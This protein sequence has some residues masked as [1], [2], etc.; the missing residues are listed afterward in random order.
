MAIPIRQ[1]LLAYL[2]TQLKTITIA[3]GYSTD[4]G[5]NGF[6]W[7]VTDFAPINTPGFT[8][9]DVDQTAV[10][11]PSGYSGHIANLEI[12]CAL[13][14]STSTSDAMI[15]ADAD[16]R[17]CIGVDPLFNG[18]AKLGQAHIHYVGSEFSVKH[19]E[20]IVSGVKAK[21]ELRYRTKLWDPYSA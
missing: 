3:N 5:T 13:S 17:K 18:I 21:Y 10:E 7:K 8:L 11:A 6:R 19:E 15:Q 20:T 4:I 16:I 9:N 2:F 1:Q 14:A 12:I